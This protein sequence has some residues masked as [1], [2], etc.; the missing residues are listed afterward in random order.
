[1]IQFYLLSVVF[2]VLSAGLLL[3]D[4]Y[5]TSFLFLINLK[6]FYNSKKAVK[7]TFISLGLLI[8]LAVIFFPVSPGPIILGDILPAANIVLVLIYLLRNFSKAESIADFN[9][10]KRNALGFITLGV[11]LIH[12]LFPWIV[13]V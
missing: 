13:V 5:G 12:F 4:R 6:T 1:M 8:A 11:A 9:N 7:I 3:V 2:L 10:G